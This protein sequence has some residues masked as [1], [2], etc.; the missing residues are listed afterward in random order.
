MSHI[1]TSL[2]NTAHIIISLL[3]NAHHLDSIFI[4]HFLFEK[5]QSNKLDKRI[6]L[7]NGDAKKTEEKKDKKIDYFITKF[8]YVVYLPKPEP[9]PYTNNLHRKLK[10]LIKK[11]F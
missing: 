11:L 9:E 3:P 7:L 10:F 4:F 5:L 6:F 1:L 2:F 8:I